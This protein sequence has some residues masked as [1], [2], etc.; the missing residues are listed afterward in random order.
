MEISIDEKR[1]EA[2]ARMKMLGIFPDTIQQFKKD[3]LVSISEPPMGAFF[4]A[5]GEDLERIR[6]FEESH[7]ALVYVAIRSYTTIG[8]LDDFLFVSDY[9]EEWQ[10]DREDIEK[11]QALSYCFNHDSPFCSEMGSIGIA[12]TTA[13]GLRRTW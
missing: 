1:A 3:G 9:K 11:G 2:I 4:W 12:R 6:K 5:E 13:A 10:M 7:N 8:K